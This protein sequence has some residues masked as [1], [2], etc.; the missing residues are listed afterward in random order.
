LTTS[1]LSGAVRDDP[2]TRQEFL[3]FVRSVER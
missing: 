2:R 1:H 3:E